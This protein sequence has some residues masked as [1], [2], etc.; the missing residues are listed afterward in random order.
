MLTDLFGK[1]IALGSLPAIKQKHKP[2]PN[3]Y[4]KSPGS[5]PANETC[6]TCCHSY[7]IQSGSKAYWKCDL[8]KATGGPGT[9]IRL[10]SP[11]CSMWEAD[12]GVE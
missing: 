7:Q 12:G 9:D 10:K 2:K 4:A 1:P 11:A 3:G 6:K 8:V 5:G